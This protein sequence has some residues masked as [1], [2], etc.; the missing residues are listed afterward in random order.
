M[1]LQHSLNTDGWQAIPFEAQGQLFL[2]KLAPN[3][4][5][6]RQI[7]NLPAGMF[8]K[9]NASAVAELIGA[10][11]TRDEIIEKIAEINEGASHAVIEIV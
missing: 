3:S 6:L 11:L 2:S 4:P 7:A 5:F 10:G 9:M 8:E 1:T